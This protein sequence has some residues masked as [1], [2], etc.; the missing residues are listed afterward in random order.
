MNGKC[1]HISGCLFVLVF[2]Q[3]CVPN[4]T[5]Y[6]QPSV[7]GGKLQAGSCVPVKNRVAFVVGDSIFSSLPVSAY[8][9]FSGKRINLSLSLGPPAWHKIHFLSERFVVYDV[10]NDKQYSDITIAV[11]RDDNIESSSTPYPD[12]SKYKS[13]PRYKYFDVHIS[14]PDN[15]SETIE[16]RVPPVI[17]NDVEVDFPIIRF[18]RKLWMGISP[19]NC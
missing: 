10:D 16:L 2:L 15:N 4:A 6:Y 7:E 9:N 14:V 13:P 1:R 19:F 17:V 11:N 8:S 12:Y 18:H 3:G 5:V